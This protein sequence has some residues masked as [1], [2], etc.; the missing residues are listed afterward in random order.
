[1]EHPEGSVQEPSDAPLEQT[2]INYPSG[3]RRFVIVLGILF[4]VFVVSE[5]LIYQEN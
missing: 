1:M 4:G 3:F 5:Y 2:D